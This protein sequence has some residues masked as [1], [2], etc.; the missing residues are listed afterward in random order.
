MFIVR[1]GT[2]TV[3]DGQVHSLSRFTAVY[4]PAHTLYH[5]SIRLPVGIHILSSQTL[6]V[7]RNP[8][9]F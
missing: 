5:N 3:A 8:P 7:Q 6:L 4:L 2:Q 9:I 1:M